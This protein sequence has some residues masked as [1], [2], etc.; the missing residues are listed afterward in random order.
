M[1]EKIQA[2]NSKITGLYYNFVYA[3]VAFN[4]FWL[5]FVGGYGE[6]EQSCRLLYAKLE[7]FMSYMLINEGLQNSSLHLSSSF[8]EGYTP[9]EGEG[10]GVKKAWFVVDLQPK[11]QVEDCPWNGV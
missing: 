9:T 8:D 5:V 2:Q 6:K 7:S 1:L 3:Y 4:S 10:E 11:T